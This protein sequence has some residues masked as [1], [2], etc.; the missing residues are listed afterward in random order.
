[1][2][3]GSAINETCV[4]GF[5]SLAFAVGSSS[6]A[7]NGWLL[8][9]ESNNTLG[10]FAKRSLS[11]ESRSLVKR[12]GPSYGANAQNLELIQIFESTFNLSLNDSLYAVY[13][14]PF[15]G[16]GNT[17]TAN[18]S[19]LEIVDGSESGQTVPIWPLIQPARDVDLIIAFDASGET[20]YGWQNGTNIIDTANQAAA[21]GL[22]FP[23]IPTAE[24]FI[25]NQ[26]N[27]L[28]T[29]FG[30]YEDDVP[31]V[32]PPI[33]SPRSPSDPRQVLYLSNS[34]WSAYT[35]YSY[36]QSEFYP[37]QLDIIFNNS[38]AQLTYNNSFSDPEWPACLACALIHGSVKKMGLNDTAQC[39][40]C[41]LRHCWDGKNTNLTDSDLLPFAPGLLLDP[42]L[43]YTTW[44]STVFGAF[45]PA[46][47]T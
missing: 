32:R 44:N 31:L 2:F 47:Y 22:P 20:P 18:Q 6:N 36:V 30:C 39:Q 38:F 45:P 19:T 12:Q 8:E 40:G 27:I 26:Y 21:A 34:P 13:P 4:E 29:F 43:N 14:N 24:T 33:L 25:A 46:T 7:W 5:D 17:S 42:G 10:L 35:N 16:Y 1:M 28:P 41:F 11:E 37:S 3:N 9:S 15:Q 23:K